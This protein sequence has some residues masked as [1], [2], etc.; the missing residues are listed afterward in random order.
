MTEKAVQT[1]AQSIS[2]EKPVPEPAKLIL[3]GSGLVGLVSVRRKIKIEVIPISIRGPVID[4]GGNIGFY[5]LFQGLR[6]QIIF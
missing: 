4:M 2:E 1:M 3:L 6:V 5:R